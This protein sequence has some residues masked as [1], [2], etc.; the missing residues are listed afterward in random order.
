MT[1]YSEA[2]IGA[3]EL[4]LAREAYERWQKRLEHCGDT[5]ANLVQRALDLLE[6]ASKVR[7]R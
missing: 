6:E 3:L 4:S 5:N 7:S 2:Q 1:D